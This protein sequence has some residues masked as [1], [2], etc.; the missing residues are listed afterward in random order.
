MVKYIFCLFLFIS[1]VS[2][3]KYE[4]QLDTS[5]F[6]IKINSSCEEGELVCNNVR[7]QSINKKNKEIIVLKGKTINRSC[8]GSGC[9]IV[10]YKFE[11]DS[12]QYILYMS[13]KLIILKEGK[14]I[15]TEKGNWK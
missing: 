15:L 2:F 13:G 5:S 12:T 10:G 3:A 11:K 8:I 9:E 6:V 7:Y 1:N 14:V 4:S